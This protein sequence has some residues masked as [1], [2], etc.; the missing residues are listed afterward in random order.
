MKNF[1]STRRGFLV[2]IANLFASMGVLSR[3]K[4]KRNRL[5][6]DWCIREFVCDGKQVQTEHM[7]VTISITGDTLT[8]TIRLPGIPV[9]TERYQYSICDSLRIDMITSDGVQFQGVYAID[10]R[11]AT[12]A[13][14]TI[15]QGRP[16]TV[17]DP[18]RFGLN[19]ME[20][21][22]KNALT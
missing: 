16:D 15:G 1:L 22:R 6:G 10:S 4:K 17:A 7:D 2:T 8:T 21:T 20:L 11:G 18:P 19:R 14:D 12:L 13:W 3:K 5:L 9:H